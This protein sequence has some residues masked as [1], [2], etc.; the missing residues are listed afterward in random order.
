MH[1][2]DSGRVSPW[3]VAANLQS[4]K[5]V[6]CPSHVPQPESKRLEIGRSDMYLTPIEDPFF[7]MLDVP[8]VQLSNPQEINTYKG[9][10]PINN[11]KD[12]QRGVLYGSLAR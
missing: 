6:Q 3:D 7:H 12:S 4:S 8:R 5:E 10:G 11:A 2:A 1:S 9:V